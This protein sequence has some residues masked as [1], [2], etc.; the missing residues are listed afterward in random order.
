KFDVAKW[1]DL[2]KVVVINIDG[3]TLKAF[4]FGFRI[5]PNNL[6]F[7]NLGRSGSSLAAVVVADDRT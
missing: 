7:D 6:K 1:E 3:Y 5:R 2:G 4:K